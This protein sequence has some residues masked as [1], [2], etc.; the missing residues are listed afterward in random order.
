MPPMPEAEFSP[1]PG[2]APDLPERIEFLS[3]A[4]AGDRTRA[5]AC[6]R[7]VFERR[8]VVCLYEE[9]IGP[10]VQAAGTLWYEGRITMAEEHLATATAQSAV[11]ALYPSFAWPERGPRALIACVE[12]DMHEFG[13]RMVSDLLALD[14]W[15]ERYLGASASI[16]EL[17]RVTREFRPHLLGLSVTLPVFVPAARRAIRAVREA[18]PNVKILVGGRAGAAELYAEG[19]HPDAVARS[20]SEAV[21]VARAWK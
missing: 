17:M 14:G 15:D 9:L 1:M 8:G 13:A 5:E 2:N 3:A 20:G 4:L 10:A 21:K 18:W 7:A 19:P 16:D 11:A 6:A 12:G